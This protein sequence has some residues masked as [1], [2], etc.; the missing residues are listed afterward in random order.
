[1]ADIVLP[2][3]FTAAATTDA[4]AVAKNL[5]S[6]EVPPQSCLT[7]NG[8][9]SSENLT[10][11]AGVVRIEPRNLKSGAMVHA[12]MQG[13]TANLDY[14]DSWFKGL[15]R[16]AT[17]T[18]LDARYLPIP[19]AGLTY[20]LP[21]AGVPVLLTWTLT[22]VFVSA[23]DYAGAGYSSSDHARSQV[24]LFID[25]SSSGT[26]HSIRWAPQTSLLAVDIPARAISD[27]ARWYTGHHLVIGQTAGW[28]SAGLRIVQDPARSATAYA[29]GTVLQSQSRINCRSFRRVAFW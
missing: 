25:D 16:L 17:N 2:G 11:G 20:F 23:D 3:V 27:G 18:P 24:R 6:F 4:D 8:Y 28:H 10:D 9:L 5:G 7:L 1:M 26:E 19:G 21:F 29:D 12:S 13:S 15:D 22:W 14:F